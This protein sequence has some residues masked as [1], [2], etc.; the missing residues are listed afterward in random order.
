MLRKFLTFLTSASGPAA[1]AQALYSLIPPA[2]TSRIGCWRQHFPK[3][4][5]IVG[6]S[7]LG[8]FFLRAST[9]NEYIVLY[10]FKKAAKSYGIFAA[11]QDFEDSVLKEV[12]LSEYVLRSDHV[13]AIRNRLG[14]LEKEDIYIPH[15]YPFLGGSDKPETYAKGNVWVFM[16]IVARMQ[17]LCG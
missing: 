7:D 13:S 5:T 17:G 2:P 1:S 10:P 6:Y 15:P 16:D 11:T 3:Y 14:L 12:G 4:D 9:D 8:H